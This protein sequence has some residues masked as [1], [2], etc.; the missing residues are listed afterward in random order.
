MSNMTFNEQDV[1]GGDYL[2]PGEHQVFVKELNRETSKKGNPMMVV[3]MSDAHGR[4]AKEFLTLADN[5]KF[6][7][8]RFARAC[9]FTK[10]HL[11]QNGLSFEALL[12][13]KLVLIKK[14]TGVEMVEGKERKLFEQEYVPIGGGT[15]QAA[16]MDDSEIPF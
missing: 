1:A 6:K 10:E 4:T 12:G 13:K 3:T 7:V 14:Q 15:E 5:T 16:P 2:G 9:G 8:A 11:L